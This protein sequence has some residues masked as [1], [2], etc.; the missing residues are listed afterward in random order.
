[1]KKVTLTR[2]TNALKYINFDLKDEVL[3]IACG[4]GL[5]APLIHKKINRYTGIDFSGTFVKSALLTAKSNSIKNTRYKETD[6]NKFLISTKDKYNKVLIFDFTYYVDD[7]HLHKIFRLTNKVIKK[8]GFIYIYEMEKTFI[9][10]YIK[11]NLFKTDFIRIYP[12]PRSAEDIKVMLENSGF[13]SIQIHYVS[14]YN[15]FR[16]LHLFRFAPLIGKYFNAKK[17]V[18]GQKK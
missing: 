7:E 2:L 8:N 16:V 14:H 3:D 10:E 9:F 13:N 4:P 1:M 17:M 5:L 18:I 11:R 6:I 15:I 12:H